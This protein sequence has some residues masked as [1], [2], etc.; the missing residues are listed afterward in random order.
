MCA[1]TRDLESKNPR[2]FPSNRSLT[3]TVHDRLEAGVVG[4]S[5]PFLLPDKAPYLRI[6]RAAFCLTNCS[7]MT[8]VYVR[9]FHSHSHSSLLSS[10]PPPS[11]QS[12]ARSADCCLLLSPMTNRLL[13]AT[14]GYGRSTGCCDR[15]S[16]PVRIATLCCLGDW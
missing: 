9:G 8:C 12:S 4:H 13:L 6:F 2:K 16:K 3:Y 14:D 10:S 11:I 1:Y 5:I 15:R 7:H